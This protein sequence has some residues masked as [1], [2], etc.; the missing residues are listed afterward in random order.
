MQA[1]IGVGAKSYARRHREPPRDRGAAACHK[2]AD[3]KDAASHAA[4]Q[5]PLRVGLTGKRGSSVRCRTYGPPIGATMPTLLSAEVIRV[6]AARLS[7][8]SRS[9]SRSPRCWSYST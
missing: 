8:C 7:L 1:L 2:E 6:L 5:S 3:W 9:V 4:A